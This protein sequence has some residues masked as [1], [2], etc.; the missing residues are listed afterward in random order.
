MMTPSVMT[1]PDDNFVDEKGPRKSAGLLL[2]FNPEGSS[3]LLSSR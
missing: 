1:V 3:A 2:Y